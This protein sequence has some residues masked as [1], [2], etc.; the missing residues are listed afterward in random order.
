MLEYGDS[1]DR[2]FFIYLL[3]LLTKAFLLATSSTMISMHL[4]RMWPVSTLS[5][6]FGQELFTFVEPG[7][8]APLMIIEALLIGYIISFYHS[9]RL[10][11]NSIE[12]LRGPLEDR[13]IDDLVEWSMWQYAVIREYVN[14]DGF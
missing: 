14:Y 13:L 5:R 2:F 10:R 12:R 7:S 1:K 11:W 8:I 4:K 3:R 6:K 9:A